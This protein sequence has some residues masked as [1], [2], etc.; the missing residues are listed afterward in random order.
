MISSLVVCFQCS[1]GWRIS[2]ELT[3]DFGGQVPRKFPPEVGLTLG[4]SFFPFSILLL[5][6][7]GQHVA[8]LCLSL[9]SC[10]QPKMHMSKKKY[11]FFLWK[12]LPSFLCFRIGKECLLD[13]NSG[14]WSVC[15]KM[16]LSSCYLV[17]VLFHCHV[18]LNSR[19]VLFVS[20]IFHILSKFNKGNFTLKND[21]EKLIRVPQ[22]LKLK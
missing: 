9:T 3:V 12:R 7:S 21:N 11:V 6:S 10:N 15:Y 2:P 8:R 14:M 16:F 20:R 22:T 1:W 4:F 18:Q 19:N 17:K 13:S 5:A